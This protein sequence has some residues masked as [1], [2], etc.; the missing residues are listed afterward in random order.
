M[1]QRSVLV[2]GASVA[3]PALASWLARSGWDVTV[4][5]HFDHLPDQGQNVDV[6]GV[7]RQVLRRMRIEEAV[8]AAH[9]SEVGVRFVDERGRPV[10]SFPA[11]TDDSGGGTAE[12]EILRGRLAEL[13][14]E[15]SADE[16]EYRF[17]DRISALHDDEAGVD[18]EFRHGPDRRFDTVVIAEGLRSRTRSMIMP[19][20]RP[21]ELGLYI[22]HLAIPRTD[23]DSRWWRT[24][25]CG[26]G[27]AIF[28]RPDNVGTTRAGMFFTSNVRGLDRLGRD[29]I[30][31]ILRETFADVGWEAPRVLEALDNGSLYLEDIAQTRLP[32]WSR[33]RTALVGDAAYCATPISGMGTTLALT[34]AYVLAGELTARDD[35]RAAFARYEQ[36]L[37]PLVTQAQHLLPGVPN[38]VV[39]QSRA[40]RTLIHT[41][42]RLAGTPLARRLQ[43]TAG[44]FTTPRA[45]AITL[46]DYPMPPPRPMAA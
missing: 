43:A 4:V 33:G 15:Q 45:E 35:P 9:T 42:L 39:P 7:G 20:A 1:V 10:A 13:L 14:Y 24:M 6:R 8:R 2:S 11:G 36:L 16:V 32:T 40:Q 46:P 37:R 26:R 25:L 28:L 44:R 23:S 30:V 31:A 38:A 21:R 29:D 34:G 5:E 17:G 18:V 3:G 12:I 41:A 27:R 19:D 22:A